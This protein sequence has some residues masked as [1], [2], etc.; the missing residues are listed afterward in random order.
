MLVQKNY[1]HRLFYGGAASKRELQEGGIKGLP[2]PERGGVLSL[3][4][5]WSLFCSPLA[6]RCSEGEMVVWVV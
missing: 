5:G 2:R 4:K 6:L 3:S 1:Q